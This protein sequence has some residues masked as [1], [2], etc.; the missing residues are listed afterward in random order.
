MPAGGRVQVGVRSA[1]VAPRAVASNE[2]VV[3]VLTL[4]TDTFDGGAVERT[5]KIT[6]RLVGTVLGESRNVSGESRSPD[7]S[8]VK[9]A[10]G[11]PM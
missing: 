9:P 4:V 1:K 3:T 6:S 5:V 10:G 8:D 2:R 7:A 11:T